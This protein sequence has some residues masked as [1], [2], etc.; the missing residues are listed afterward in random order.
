MPILGYRGREE[1][2]ITPLTLIPLRGANWQQ[3]SKNVE[4]TNSQNGLRAYPEILPHQKRSILSY[5]EPPNCH[6]GKNQ[7]LC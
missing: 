5:P 1:L 7:K 4:N 3:M 6:I 2:C